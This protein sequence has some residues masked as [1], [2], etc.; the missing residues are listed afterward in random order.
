[1]LGTVG[2]ALTDGGPA[3]SVYSFLF[4]WIGYT[5]VYASL[6]ELVSFMPTA[7]GQYHWVWELAPPAW[8][9]FLSWITGWQIVLAWQTGLASALYLG[10]TILQGM[11]VLNYPGYHFE[12]W[13]ATLIICGI[14]LVALLFNTVLVRLLRIAEISILAIHCLGFIII[15]VPILHFAPKASAHDVFAR[16]L[17]LGGYSNGTAW[18]VGLVSPVFSFIGEHLLCLCEGSNS[19]LTS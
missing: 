5:A 15:L 13:H 4:C 8:R 19:H 1:M 3:G 7:A 18:F 12:R 14:I 11:V 2:I 17:S 6:A 16:Y 9:K 10:G